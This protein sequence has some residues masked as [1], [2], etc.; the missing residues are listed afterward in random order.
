MLGNVWEWCQDW[1]GD[2]LA[3]PAIDPVGPG[4]GQD[5]VIRGGSWSNT[6]QHA[7]SA[8]RLYSIHPTTGTSNVGFRCAQVQPQAGKPRA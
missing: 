2:Y 4:E 7:R 3:E 6:A 5:R 1:Y 8:Y